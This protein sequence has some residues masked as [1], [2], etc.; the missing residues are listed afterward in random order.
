MEQEL[1]WL[2]DSVG[3]VVV[4]VDEIV[5]I[6]SGCTVFYDNIHCRLVDAVVELSCCRNVMENRKGNFI[7]KFFRSGNKNGH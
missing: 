6:S 2:I 7:N 1:R 4:V 3:V 5:V